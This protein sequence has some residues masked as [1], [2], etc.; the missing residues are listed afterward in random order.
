MK[1]SAALRFAV[2]Q[3]LAGVAAWAAVTFTTDVKWD[4]A[5]LRGFIVTV[6]TTLVGLL[7][8]HEPFVGVKYRAQVPVPPAERETP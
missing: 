2:R 6:A 5:L 4:G 1:D 7:G 8:A 3:L